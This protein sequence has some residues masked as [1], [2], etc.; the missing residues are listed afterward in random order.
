MS[1][2]PTT[3]GDDLPKQ[4]ARVRDEIVPIYVEIGPSGAFA[5][6]MMR[7]MLDRADKAMIEGDI[8][9]IVQLYLPTEGSK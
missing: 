4:M 8:V 7:D 5:L 9:A 1:S 6:M 3:L 2:Q